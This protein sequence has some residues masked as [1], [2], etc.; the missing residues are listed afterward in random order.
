[1]QSA[2]LRSAAAA[3]ELSLIYACQSSRAM[4]QAHSKSGVNVVLEQVIYTLKIKQL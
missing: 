1:M 3:A 2:G 4:R